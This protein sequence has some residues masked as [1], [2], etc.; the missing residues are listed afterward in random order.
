[1]L[2]PGAGSVHALVGWI[3]SGRILGMQETVLIPKNPKQITKGTCATS[4]DIL[5]LSLPWLFGMVPNPSNLG[6]IF[7]EHRRNGPLVRPLWM[8]EKMN[9]R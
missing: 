4:M 3:H 7:T 1:M 6:N 9:D 8:N 5:Q 2:P